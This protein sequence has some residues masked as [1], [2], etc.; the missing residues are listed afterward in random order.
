MWRD[1]DGKEID[2]DKLMRLDENGKF[3][4]KNTKIYIDDEKQ[5]IA[6]INKFPDKEEQRLI[7]KYKKK[8]TKQ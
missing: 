4:T 8:E 2:I 6:F 5:L 3:I 1:A 7:F